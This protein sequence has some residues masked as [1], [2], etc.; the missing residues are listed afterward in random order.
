[1]E[2]ISL[3]RNAIKKAVN[4]LR[5]GVVIVYP[6]ETAYGLGCDATN[7]H[8]VKR[9]FKIKGRSSKKP[10]PLIVG[11]RAMAERVI[12]FDALIA[13]LA[14]RAWPGPLTVVAESRIK[15]NELRIGHWAHLVSAGT[16]SIGVRVSAL[17]F[18]RKLS[19]KLG[20]PIVAT[21]ANYADGGE[22]YT[23]IDVLKQF[24]Q[25]YLPD[26]CID[27]GRLRHCKPSTI[28]TVRDGH[29][30]TLRRGP[31]SIGKLE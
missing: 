3:N 8:A 30:V 5:Q 17:P 27:G 20:K 11:N 12:Q 6:T 26:L 15:N 21:S 9:I 14:D 10:L 1:M 25:K 7:V 28:I 2:I 4:V 31:I 23:L 18:A 29:I 19:E 13:R 24:D 16:G 22:C